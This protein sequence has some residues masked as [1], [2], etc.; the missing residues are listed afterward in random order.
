MKRILVV[1]TA[2]IKGEELAYL[3]SPPA[4]AAATSIVI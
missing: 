3:R 1:G 2:D 4:E